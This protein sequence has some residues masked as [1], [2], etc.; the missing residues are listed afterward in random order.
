MLGSGERG[1]GWR[2][3]SLH[4]PAIAMLSPPQWKRATEPRH[5]YSWQMCADPLLKRC[6]AGFLR[7]FSCMEARCQGAEVLCQPCRVGRCGQ[8]GGHVPTPIPPTKLCIALPTAAAT[9][10][11]LRR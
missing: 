1:R 8:R 11:A 3:S 7:G 2:R 10:A 5:A 4:P 6:G 9:A